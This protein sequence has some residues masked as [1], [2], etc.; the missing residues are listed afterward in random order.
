MFKDDKK[1]RELIIT[2][3]DKNYFVEASAGSGKTTSLVYRMVAMVES[4]IPVDKICTIT[5]TK[6][7]A[8]EF[9]ARFQAMLS[10][11]SVDII[12]DTDKFLGKRS[13]ESIVRCLNALKDIDL[14]YLGT[15]DSFL[16]MIAHEMPNEIK[17]PSNAEIV[18]NVTVNKV[19][20]DY[21]YS[22]LADDSHPLHK[23]TLEFNE[24]FSYRAEELF[25]EGINVI[26]SHR[27]SIIDYD[28]SLIGI[29][30]ELYL[31]NEKKD[32]LS[33]VK[34]IA[35]MKDPLTSKDKEIARQIIKYQYQDVV[36][37]SLNDSFGVI[38]N[39]LNNIKKIDSF[40][41]K[42]VEGYPIEDILVKKEGTRSRSYI[43]SEPTIE[44]FK[45]VEGKVDDYLHSLYFELSI[46][47]RKEIGEILKKE[48]MF[49]FDDFLYYVKDAFKIDANKD[50]KILDHIYKRH[51]YFLLDENQDTNPVQTELFFYITGTKKNSDWTKVEPREGSIFIVGDPKQSIYGFRGASV[52]AYLKTKEIF[53]KKNEVLYLTRNFR[54]NV[55]LKEWFNASMDDILNHG[56]DA[57][58]H[59]PIPIEDKEYEYKYINELEKDDIVFDAEY[60]YHALNN[61]D[62]EFVAKLIYQ[63]VNDKHHKIIA[64]CKDKDGNTA[65]RYRSIDYK[66]FLVVP[67]STSVDNYIETFKKYHI[68]LLIEAQIPF[69]KSESLLLLITLVRMIKKP[70]DAS[71]LLNV[72]YGPLFKMDDLDII[73]LKNEGFN[74][75]IRDISS[76]QDK[77]SGVIN[78]IKFLASLY[79]KYKDLCFSSLMNNLMNNRDLHIL[80][81]VNTD[82]LEYTYFAIEKIK[83]LEEEGRLTDINQFNDFIDNRIL[84]D[85]KDDN[86][87]LRFKDKIDRVK[88]ANLHKVKGLQAP[89]VLLIRPVVPYKEAHNYL[90]YRGESSTYYASSIIL[91]DEHGNKKTMAASS[92]Y[93]EATIAK[94]QAYLDAEHDR[95]VYVAATRAESVLM[96][97]SADKYKSNE[98]DYWDKLIKHIDDSR[99]INPIPEFDIK[100]VEEVEATY[101]EP[102][103]NPHCYKKSFKS[104]TPSRGHIA[105]INNNNDE[106]VEVREDA[107]LVGTLVHRLLECLVSS[108]NSYKDIS[109]LVKSI[110]SQ[111]IDGDK[112]NDLLMNVASIMLKGGYKQIN[113]S[114]PDDLLGLLKEAKYIACEMPFAY[115]KHQVIVNG[116]IDLIYLDKNDHYHII[117][118]KTGKENDI[119]ILEKNYSKQLSDYIE[120]LKEIGIKADAHIYHIDVKE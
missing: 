2:S 35:E 7:A 33:I 16:N 52:K 84:I 108:F 40:P 67:F 6:A 11:R 32:F 14:C 105:S 15:I 104:H 75:D 74:L 66:D 55:P 92:K 118:Y 88:I 12:D 42:I 51:S 95:L 46:K 61:E 23:M 22:V 110:T 59:N 69:D 60:K 41:S 113:S 96:V 24:A 68:P 83:E 53:A 43:Y 47:A 103:I 112:Y 71:S 99:V 44:V 17:I 34:L 26:S 106:I 49:S 87:V 81:V 37:S 107:T 58:E 111:Y 82:Y 120:A 64:R 94:W 100:E 117:D 29:D 80:N 36:S 65:L 13:K 30:K 114:L 39:I 18:D 19:I 21:Y 9:F 97:A 101:H 78:N 89:I 8:D 27:D 116:V 25:I 63:L 28:K 115:Q 98:C 10:V 91:R 93:D 62:P 20:L 54:S 3:L 109:L 5:F 1:E 77:D 38:K 76:I 119:S 56:D 102:D 4:G 57:L 73:A 45:K 48:G 72:L 86:R 50:R 70:Y 85:K 31:I 90:D 79:D